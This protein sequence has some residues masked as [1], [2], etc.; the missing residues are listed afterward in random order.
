MLANEDEKGN[1][2][3]VA[4]QQRIYFYFKIR[5]SEGSHASRKKRVKDAKNIV[6]NFKKEKNSKEILMIVLQPVMD[7]K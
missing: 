3:A 2:K 5:T 6:S 1:K 4:F 7:I